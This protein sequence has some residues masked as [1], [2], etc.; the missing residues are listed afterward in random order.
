MK[1]TI[2]PVRFNVDAIFTADWHLREDT[3]ECRTDDFHE[4]QWSKVA[5]VRRLQEK[6]KCPVFHS[7]DLFHKWK[8]SPLLL[9]YCLEELPDQFYTVF[10]NHDLPQHSLDLWYK[11]SIRTLEAAGKLTVLKGGH[12]NDK[13]REENAIRIKDRKIFVWHVM[14]YAGKLPWFGSEAP[15]STSL[16]KKYEWAD[17]IITGDNH[18][19]FVSRYNDRL[20]V[21]PGSLMR[22]S[23]AQHNHEPCVWLYNADRNDVKAHYFPVGPD[24]ITQQ[25][26]ERTKER[27]E[28]IQ[29]FVE[30]LGS[31]YEA[32]LD[33]RE[34]LKRFEADNEI[35][36]RTMEIVYSAL[37]E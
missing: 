18:Q 27:D 6:Y 1:R 7:G 33:F 26:L 16:L 25:H 29:V 13:P 12:W 21:N 31:E 22:Q 9:T 19:T 36:K 37:D 15:E 10:G 14:T 35:D 30:R 8:A 23:A 32:T 11:T 24:D 20:L 4:A 34:N 3:P 28:R 2:D 17:C 5:Q